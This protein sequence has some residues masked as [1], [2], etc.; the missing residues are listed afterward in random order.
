M[1]RAREVAR[2]YP[3]H[4]V[5]GLS[6][7]YAE[8]FDD[9]AAQFRKDV[10]VNPNDTEEAIWA[11]LCEAQ[12]LGFDRAR[13]RL[14][15]V[16]RDPRGY[17][18]EAY[19]L[20]NGEGSEEELRAVGNKNGP[21]DEFYSLLYVGLWREARGETEAAK[22]AMVAAVRTVYGQRSGDYMAGLA[23]VHCKRRGWEVA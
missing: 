8:R 16:G 20:F 14:L 21:A 23:A 13:E 4:Y 2:V 15:K 3:V 5:P 10:A 19:R 6:L 12:T 7:Y 17:M 22:E 1:C 11:F 9:G 18:R